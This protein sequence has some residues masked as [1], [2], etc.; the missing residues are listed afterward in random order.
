M[1]P[2]AFHVSSLW[3][4]LTMRK[5]ATLLAALAVTLL[6][7]GAQAQNLDQGK[8]AAKLFADNCASCHH[9][10]R[11]LAKG[12]ISL[13]LFLYL[14]QHYTSNTSSAWALASYLESADGTRGARGPAR[15]TKDRAPSTRTLSSGPRPPASVPG[16]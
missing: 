9:R 6:I 16:R 8:S 12:R 5:R 4:R 3:E 11:G 2:P 1:V 15:A 14:Q 13:S 7:G 10:A